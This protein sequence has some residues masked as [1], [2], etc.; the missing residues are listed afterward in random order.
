MESD[1]P[2]SLCFAMNVWWSLFRVLWDCSV[3]HHCC[4]F[5]P[6]WLTF[7]LFS[8]LETTFLSL[9]FALLEGF[10]SRFAWALRSTLLTFTSDHFLRYTQI[11]SVAESG[12]NLA[13]ATILVFEIFYLFSLFSGFQILLFFLTYF[14]MLD[15]S[16]RA[17]E[18]PIEPHNLSMNLN[19]KCMKDSGMLQPGISQ[20]SCESVALRANRQASHKRCPL[21]PHVTPACL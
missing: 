4:L 20:L 7:L 16:Y 21:I 13:N 6:P 2:V 19:P 14:S 11:L 8:S 3:T 15:F 18:I 17:P 9:G 12:R 10:F 1:S 5:R